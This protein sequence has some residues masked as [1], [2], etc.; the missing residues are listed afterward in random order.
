MGCESYSSDVRS[1]IKTQHSH[2]T[3]LWSAAARGCESIVQLLL[4]RGVDVNVQGELYCHALT[5]A[6]LGGNEA[7]VR[8]LLESRAEFN[9]KYNSYDALC[10]HY[11]RDWRFTDNY[12]KWEELMRLVQEYADS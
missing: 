6:G 4:E 3:G 12:M 8:L 1:D 9:E 7:T 2:E 10:D 11:Y 5:A